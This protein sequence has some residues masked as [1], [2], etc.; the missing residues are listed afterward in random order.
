VLQQASLKQVKQEVVAAAQKK[1]SKAEDRHDDRV[2]CVVCMEEERSVLFLPCNHMC[3]CGGCAAAACRGKCPAC[4]AEILQ[5]LT[6]TL[7]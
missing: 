2:L 3:A 6:V 4:R 7:S 1:V 5:S